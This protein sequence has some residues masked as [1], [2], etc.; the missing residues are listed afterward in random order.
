[1]AMNEYTIRFLVAI[2]LTAALLT[3]W[4][5]RLAPSIVVVWA[6]AATLALAAALAAL[7][8]WRRK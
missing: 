8:L 6:V 3:Y 7:L 1:M 5:T 4:L 2:L